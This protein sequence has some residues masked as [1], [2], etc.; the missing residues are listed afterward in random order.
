MKINIRD[1]A[2]ECNYSPAAVSN[3]LNNKGSLKE[4]TRKKILATIKRLKYDPYQNMPWIKKSR[5]KLIGLVIPTDIE[6]DSFFSQ[7]LV[8]AKT[9][10]GEKGY[11]CVVYYDGEIAKLT[12]DELHKGRNNIPCDGLVYF[13]PNKG[14]DRSLQVFKN[15]GIPCT[16]IRRKTQVNGVTMLNDNDQKGTVLALDHLLGLGHRRIGMITAEIGARDFVDERL[17]AYNEFIRQHGLAQ[18]AAWT[19]MF[20]ENRTAPVLGDWLKGL[21]VSPSRPTAFFC[22]DDNLAIELMKNLAELEY[23]VPED[24]AVVGYDNDSIGEKIHPA[25]TTVNVPVKEMVETA[26]RIIFDELARDGQEKPL[27]GQINIEF[28]NELVVRESCGANRK[29]RPL[30][31]NV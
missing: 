26:C 13:C 9:M 21:M 6:L 14:W 29:G 8:K 2:R 31:E 7:A 23:R 27:A 22:W 3:V 4:E 11:N 24:M 1:I 30:L 20:N 25:L 15:W 10:A 5:T 28:G 12:T 18:N 17:W 19:F 16:L